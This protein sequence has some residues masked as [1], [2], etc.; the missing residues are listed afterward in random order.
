MNSKIEFYVGWRSLI[1]DYAISG[2]WT[3]DG[4]FFVVT[5]SLG[6]VYVFD[7]V[8]G[9]TIWSKI[10][11]HELGGL[12]VA[13][14][15]TENKF[16]TTGQDGKI[17][18]WETYKNNAQL[19]SDLGNNW[20]ENAAWS[21]D[22][23][24]LAVSCS[25][26][27]YVFS[28]DGEQI[29]TSADHISTVSKLVW[30]T[31]NEVVTSCYGRVSFFEGVTGALK[32]KLEWQGSLVS[33]VLSPNGEIVVCGSQDNTVHFWR[34]STEKDSM[35]SG[36]PM[37]PSNLAFDKS[38]ILLATGGS[39][40]I[41]VWNF[42][43]DGPEGSTPLSLKFHKKPITSLA[44]ANHSMN[45]ASGSRDGGLVIW[46]LS[47]DEKEGGMCDTHV[48]DSISNLYW[49]PKDQA[50]AALDK[51]GGVTIFFRGRI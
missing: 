14:H 50:I 35:M 41:T 40:D 32:Q 6:G 37:K 13:M 17:F 42:G 25:R 3:F 27:V 51:Q 18:I 44:F 1:N 45:L 11:A 23:N 26:K 7:G 8:S 47:T 33:M 48:A 5:D 31:N 19:I 9:K 36:Y 24:L 29:W 34:R 43:G 20:V 49:H 30:S 28:Q 46:G 38:G 21:L 2:G 10:N 15:P 4:N 22:G 16:V 39:E 12:V